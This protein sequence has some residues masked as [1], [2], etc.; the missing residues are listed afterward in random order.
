[1]YGYTLLQFKQRQPTMCLI[2]YSLY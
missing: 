2:I 1:M